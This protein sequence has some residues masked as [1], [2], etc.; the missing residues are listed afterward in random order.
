MKISLM[1]S[2]WDSVERLEKGEGDG[3][4]ECA[5]YGFRVNALENSDKNVPND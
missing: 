3:R 5:F 4:D 1:I 2:R